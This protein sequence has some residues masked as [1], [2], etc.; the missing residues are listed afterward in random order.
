MSSQME[1]NFLA[2]LLSCTAHPYFQFIYRYFDL[3]V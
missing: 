3:L 2:F 1:V